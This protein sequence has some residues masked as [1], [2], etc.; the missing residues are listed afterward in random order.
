MREGEYNKRKGQND[1][2]G[3]QITSQKTTYSTRKQG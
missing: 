1:K 3:R 2:N